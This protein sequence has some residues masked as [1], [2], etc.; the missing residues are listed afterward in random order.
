MKRLAYCRRILQAA[1][2]KRIKHLLDETIFAVDELRKCVSSDFLHHEPCKSIAPL[3]SIGR[4]DSSL[5][6]LKVI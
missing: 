4:N 1:V 6:A 3:E 5:L 2:G